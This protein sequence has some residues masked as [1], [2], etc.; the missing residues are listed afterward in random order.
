MSTNDRCTSFLE[1][2]FCKQVW[3]AMK[4]ALGSGT[5]HFVIDIDK[6]L[7]SQTVDSSL[8]VHEKPQDKKKNEPPMSMNS[9]LNVVSTPIVHEEDFHGHDDSYGADARE[10]RKKYEKTTAEY[11]LQHALLTCLNKLAIPL[12]RFRKE[13]NERNGSA[14]GQSVLVPL[15][16]ELITTLSPYLHSSCPSDLHDLTV[17]LFSRLGE[18]D[19]DTV[20]ISMNTLL[21]QIVQSNSMPALIPCNDRAQSVTDG[22]KR[23]LYMPKVKSIT[24][25]GGLKRKVSP[26]SAGVNAVL[27]TLR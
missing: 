5:S 20:W 17:T 14:K 8:L 11:K 4:R 7:P 24:S 18:M 10:R 16:K 19:E 21:G 1:N 2:R 22:K 15:V 12:E 6:M 13:N 23:L 9:L 27:D 3:P 25:K 26:Y